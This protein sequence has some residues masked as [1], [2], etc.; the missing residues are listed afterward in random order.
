M[1]EDDWRHLIPAGKRA[2]IP[3]NT[4]EITELYVTFKTMDDNGNDRLEKEELQQV[5]IATGQ[6]ATISAESLF[7]NASAKAKVDGLDFAE[8]LDLISNNSMGGPMS[9]WWK[10][11]R[12]LVK[13]YSD[14]KTAN[15]AASLQIQHKKRDQD[16]DAL[17]S[18]INKGQRS[19][20][21]IQYQRKSTV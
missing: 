3:L 21:H 14:R 1:S 9:N 2:N 20:V 15:L 16:D 13:T 7:E 18:F 19:A 8:F 11:N 10:N 5:L 4:D 12:K 17:D 6:E